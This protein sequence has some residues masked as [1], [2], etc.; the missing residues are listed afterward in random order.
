MFRLCGTDT[1]AKDG[2]STGAAFR[3]V[4]GCPVAVRFRSIPLYLFGLFG[5][6]GLRRGFHGSSMDLF[7]GEGGHPAVGKGYKDVISYTGHLYDL[8][9]LIHKN[10]S[11]RL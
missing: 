3:V 4:E 11:E 8:R 7:S 1:T 2:P 9:C 10:P 5:S 6:I